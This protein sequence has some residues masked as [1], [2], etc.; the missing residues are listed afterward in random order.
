MTLTGKQALPVI[1]GQDMHL[2]F[3]Q[4]AQDS[5]LQV[6]KE[7]KAPMMLWNDSNWTYFD[8]AKIRVTGGG[9]GHGCK[10]FHHERNMPD[11]G[12][13]GG[14]GGHGGHVYLRV[15]KDLTSL[16]YLKGQVHYAGERGHNGRGD[17]EWGRCGRHKI[18]DVPAGTCVYVREMWKDGTPDGESLGA[19]KLLTQED[20]GKHLVGELLEVGQMLRVARGG[21]G[22]RGNTHFFSH[23][24]TAPW[25]SEDGEKGKS[26]WID[27]E[28]KMVADVGLIG[29][30]NAGK[31]SFLSAVTNKLAKVAPYAFST[32][33]PN[34]GH[35]TVNEHGGL[36]LC[37]VPGLIE[38]AHTGKGMGIK[39]LRHIE[40]CQTLIHIVSA[41]SEDPIG[42]Y[43][44]IQ[45]ELRHFSTEV[46]NMPQVIAVNKCDIT[47]AK[48]RLPELMAA[49]RKRCG[50]SRVFDISVAT[51]YH[52]DE[53]MRRVAKWH[54]SIMKD[55]LSESGIPDDEARLVVGQQKITQ[56]G[57]RMASV[58]DQDRVELDEMLPLRS[59]HAKSP[60]QPK[61][62]WDV[63]ED[64]WRLK[65]PEVER[66]VERANWRFTQQ[67]D[68]VNQCLKRAGFQEALQA[69][70]AKGD[71]Y[72]IIGDH[73]FQYAP[74]RVGEESR[75]LVY[76]L[77]FAG[78][79]MYTD[80][81]PEIDGYDLTEEESD[82]G[83]LEYDPRMDQYNL[84]DV[85]ELDY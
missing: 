77:D 19:N 32:T 84:L 20:A 35:Y 50:H 69:A 15:R 46:A 18:I 52:L 21:R 61:V 9:G 26:R 3:A 24:N 78:F 17:N 63:L 6:G 54:Y 51:R 12:P 53:F 22:G 48:E 37:D 43:E 55:R 68:R 25:V 67:R 38:G 44:T 34:V 16:K 33:E 76:D 13:D 70:G 81:E 49:L 83:K 60:Y 1:S 72:V 40:R 23:R 62:I 36:T 31:S 59:K 71:D 80:G 42:D 27:L 30:P 64:S 14:N 29:C 66:I 73:R 56:M 7:H 75:M 11:M 82:F 57:G 65:H 5:V 41:D 85:E 79:E 2:D 47:E 58:R 8:V 10:S 4:R 39:F 74:W 45:A 28:L